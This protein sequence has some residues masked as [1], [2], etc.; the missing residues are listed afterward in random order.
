[1]L[2]S[3]YFWDSSLSQNNLRDSEC[4]GPD[5][6]HANSTVNIHVKII[7]KLRLTTLLETTLYA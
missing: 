3:G 6:M 5:Q 4:N 2:G 7:K 1:M